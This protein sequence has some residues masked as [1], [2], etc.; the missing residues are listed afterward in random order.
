MKSIWKISILMLSLVSAHTALAQSRPS[1]LIIGDSQTQK[2]F[3]NGLYD[4]LSKSYEV[5]SYGI[6]NANSATLTSAAS[7]ELL[8]GDCRAAAGSDPVVS[9]HSGNASSAALSTN[10]LVRTG[11][12][13]I[14]EGA[15]KHHNPDLVLIQLGDAMADGYAGEIDNQRI[16]QQVTEIVS[17]LESMAPNVPACQW[18]G[19][20]FGEDKSDQKPGWTKREEQVKA[21]NQ[22]IAS[23]L[24][25][26]SVECTLIDGSD[27]SLKS[28]LGS[29]FTTDGLHLK[30]DAARKWASFVESQVPQVS[31]QDFTGTKPCP[32][33]P[34]GTEISPQASALLGQIGAV[35]GSLTDDSNYTPPDLATISRQNETDRM[36][37]SAYRYGNRPSTDKTLLPKSSSGGG[38][39]A[40]IGSFLAGLLEGIGN[41][42]SAIFGGIT[43]W[44][45]GGASD[46][47]ASASLTENGAVPLDPLERNSNLLAYQDENA[48]R[49]P[50]SVDPFNSVMATESIPGSVVALTAPDLGDFENTDTTVPVT[51]SGPKP[52]YHNRSPVT[53]ST[54]IPT[55][56]PIN[57]R[58]LDA[59]EETLLSEGKRLGAGSWHRLNALT[60]TAYDRGGSS[61][62][63][64]KLKEAYNE[65]PGGP[66]WGGLSLEQ[67]ADRIRKH[68]D[69]SLRRIKETSEQVGST[70]RSSPHTLSPMLD[71]NIAVC[72]SFIETRGTLNPQSMNYTMCRERNNR[73]ST[74]SGLGQMTRTT[75]RGLYKQGKLPITTTSDYEGKGVDELF[76]SIT[77]DVG[78]QMEVL[79][80]LMNEELKRASRSGGSRNDILLRAVTAYDQDNQSKYVRMFD[81]CHRCMSQMSAAQDPMHCYREMGN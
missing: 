67:R 45:T 25:D 32:P 54:Y 76:Y 81:R 10:Q 53:D 6:C 15:V 39:F 37:S 18:V 57:D 64:R 26:Q 22:A 59:D 12:A 79:Y 44:F 62:C 16:K 77:D 58:A 11:S 9:R 38:F 72:I 75:F 40:G 73:W 20:T 65:V 35:T 17:K 48:G 80:R 13:G 69:I 19:P 61:W 36:F 14:L 8:Q 4:K 56:A 1:V 24:A 52:R 51:S 55:D 49:S 3:G 74:A 21:V 33:T 60:R 7:M 70:N 71:S 78:L 5:H 63:E 34:T 31:G 29:D 28:E 23:A 2:E 27:A 43:S 42:F 46:L 68:A 41:F 30:P 66:I 50:S 47:P